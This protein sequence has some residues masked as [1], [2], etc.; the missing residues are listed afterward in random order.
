M[1][2]NFVLSLL[3]SVALCLVS[4]AC[5]V[6]QSGDATADNAAADE[7]DDSILSRKWS[8]PAGRSPDAREALQKFQNALETMRS[9]PP[10]DVNW[11]GILPDLYAIL[12]ADSDAMIAEGPAAEGNDLQSILLARS[13]P[14]FSLKST[15][16]QLIGEL[17]PP[18]RAAWQQLYA[19]RAAAELQSALKQNDRSALENVA[20]S[21]FH[22]PA[23]YQAVARLGSEYLDSGRPV[24]AARSFERLRSAAPFR[25]DNEPFISLRTAATWQAL[26]RDDRSTEILTDLQKWMAERGGGTGAG[27]ELLK[28]SPKELTKW[29]RQTVPGHMSDEPL[30][31]EWRQ[32]QGSS[33]RSGRVTEISPVGKLL[34]SSLTTGFPAR[35]TIVDRGP[36]IAPWLDSDDEPYPKTQGQIAAVVEL[37]LEHLNRV[38]RESWTV[39]LPACYPITVGR[40]AVFRTMR[41]LRAVDIDSGEIRWES[42]LSDPAF[43]DQFSLQSAR[44]AVNI[45]RR[46]LRSPVN[47]VQDALLWARSR[48]DRTTGTLS[49]DGRFVYCIDEC[50]IPLRASGLGR[51]SLLDT[52]PKRWNRLRAYDLKSGSLVWDIGGEPSEPRLGTAGTA[53]LGVPV[54]SEN[55]LLILGEDDGSIRLLSLQPETGELNW[56]HEMMHA[57]S[58][59][60]RAAVRRASGDSPTIVNGLVICS[61]TTGLITAFDPSQRRIAWG[62]RYDSVI[63]PPPVSRTTFMGGMHQYLDDARLKDTERWRDSTIVAAGGRLLA[64]PLDSN[65][66][67]CLN[68]ADGKV[69]WS[70]MRGDGVYLAGVFHEQVVIA[71]DSGLTALKLSTGK[72]LWSTEFDRRIV[73]GRGICSGDTY[74]LPLSV[75]QA[76][77][78]QPKNVGA[79]DFTLK[80]VR[81]SLVS[82]DLKTGRILAESPTPHRRPLGN[83]AAAA[84][85]L[86]SQS[87]DSVVAI[88]TPDSL[89]QR[90]MQTLAATPSDAAMLEKRARVRLH[91]G[92]Q[93]EGFTDLMKAVELKA[94]RSAES[95]LIQQALERR[96]RGK[97]VPVETFQILQSADLNAESRVTLRRL[98]IDSLNQEGRLAEAFQLI[99]DYAE[100]DHGEDG[101]DGF[102]D[103]SVVDTESTVPMHRWLS[104]QLSLV[105]KKSQNASPAGAKQREQIESAITSSLNAARSAKDSA[106]VKQWLDRF[107]WHTLAATAR[108]ELAAG[109]DTDKDLPAIESQLLPLLSADDQSIALQAEARLLDLWIRKNRVK[110]ALV[111]LDA[112]A[113]A[114][115]D[116]VV[117]EGKTGTQLVQEWLALDSVKQA[118]EFGDWPD[119]E[120]K[121]ATAAIPPVRE[122]RRIQL[123]PIGKRSE[124]TRGWNLEIVNDAV[125]AFDSMGRSAWTVTE[126]NLP[127]LSTPISRQRTYA[128]WMSSGHLLVLILG[129]D[130]ITLDLSGDQPKV[131]WSR[132]VLAY[133]TGG[134]V[135][136]RK[137]SELGHFLLLSSSRSSRPLGSV[138]LLTSQYLA[139]RSGPILHVVHARTG[140]PVWNR[141]LAVPDGLIFGS[142]RYIVI[143]EPGPGDTTVI[144]LRDGRTIARVELPERYVMTAA[145]GHDPVLLVQSDKGWAVERFDIL[146]G[147]PVWSYKGD[148]ES[149][150]RPLSRNSMM[151]LSPNGA[152]RVLDVH[153]GTLSFD[154][155]S[156]PFERLGTV[157]GHETDFGFVCFTSSPGPAFRAGVTPLPG[158]GS[159]QHRVSG[160]AFA[161]D[162]RSRKLLWRRPIE[163]QQLAPSQPRDIPAVVL[164]GVNRKADPKR[165]GIPLQEFPLHVLD[166]RTGKSILQTT[167]K[168]AVSSYRTSGNPESRIVDLSFG[169]KK[170]TFHFKD[171]PAADDAQSDQ[172]P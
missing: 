33:G 18:G 164:A 157:Y 145:V 146:T 135:T 17:P 35:S 67:L 112:F 167:E 78:S 171:E 51:A 29:L 39:Q 20:L 170:L 168:E 49:S 105:W 31:S 59:V 111:R 7:T 34:W 77:P 150:V 2:S 70:H 87:Y 73:S 65:E 156:E 47:Q 106:A 122:F 124:A 44:A 63:R 61:A 62:T 160:S 90:I 114:A 83:L 4:P 16:E 149:V 133:D 6:A 25:R 50:G 120:P 162:I 21:F 91:R 92:L 132:S 1:T 163:D 169:T 158:Q 27:A 155:K 109:L 94:G 10:D 118:A 76:T 159:N 151:I 144:D 38:D 13:Q 127:P 152:I 28:A 15:T 140:K 36:F 121:L 53:F 26:G 24:L 98:R 129:T 5:C 64:T 14:L 57:I 66:L 30:M 107:E 11:N 110:P 82:V 75:V 8:A 9:T 60:S 71:R 68:A 97:P 19:E 102:A 137:R 139:Y 22:T 153:S 55:E 3:C 88:E 142:D 79:D 166:P 99:L 101:S 32:F 116:T 147:K 103:Y 23:G 154:L 115:G 85:V 37:G 69:I 81:G 104:S 54:R 143:A 52:G 108:L 42:F 113:A 136:G 134:F 148:A 43:S 58:P 117:F 125:I 89:D 96:R 84:G 93:E 41:K 100:A 126:E 123:S 48:L 165:P 72:P 130:F 119:R 138:D 56:S 95:L 128:G 12:S 46:D 131:L 161:I 80:P 172:A 45:P 86:I 141:P 40:V 74:H